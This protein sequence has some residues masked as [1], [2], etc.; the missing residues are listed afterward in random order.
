[1]TAVVVGYDGEEAAVAALDARD[2]GGAG[3]GAELV[4][5]AVV[6]WRSTPAGPKTGLAGRRAAADDPARRAARAQPLLAEVAAERVEPTGLTADYVWES[7]SPRRHPARGADRGAALVVVGKGTTA[8]RALARRGHRAEVE[9]SRRLPRPARGSA[10]KRE[11]RNELL[12]PLLI[13]ALLG[14]GILLVFAASDASRA[15]LL[16]VIPAAV[17]ASLI[18]WAIRHPWRPQA[19]DAPLGVAAAADGLHRLLVISDAACDADSLLEPASR[20]P[21]EAL[22]VAPALSSR[23]DRLTGDESAYEDAQERLDATLKALEALGIDATGRL[24]PADPLQAADDGLREF[25]ADEVVFATSADGPANWLE[26][27]VIETAR[28][29]YAARVTHVAVSS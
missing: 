9:R 6:E 19:D 22:V 11:T 28:A 23:L 8:A 21:V 25:A 2:R 20:R 15:H 16:W 1:M 12:V 7:A 5:V 14:L 18:V 4:V 29:R 27:G 3:A 10:M 13:F 17:A 26:D 24:G